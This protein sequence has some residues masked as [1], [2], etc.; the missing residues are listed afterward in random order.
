LRSL[1]LLLSSIRLV[2]RLKS[3]L[4]LHV[5]VLHRLLILLN[6]PVDNGID[7]LLVLDVLFVRELSLSL[8]LH[9]LFL[10]HLLADNILV[11]T[12]L[13]SHLLLTNLIHA[14]LHHLLVEHHIFNGFLLF[15]LH[16]LTN[17]GSTLLVDVCHLQT[18]LELA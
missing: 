2:H 15:P 1:Q 18:L 12:T 16:G 14:S 7:L 5:V 9:H 17:L 8:L 6:D 11:P 3:L 10:E 13:L 4:L